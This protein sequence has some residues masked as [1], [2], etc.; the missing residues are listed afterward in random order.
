MVRSP[1]GTG[2]A[3]EEREAERFVAVGE[4]DKALKIYERL[5]AKQPENTRLWRRIKAIAWM[6][7]RDVDPTET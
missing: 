2:A 7:R 5:A 6:L 3:L 4:L 1:A